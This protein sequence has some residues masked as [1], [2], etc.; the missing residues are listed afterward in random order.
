MLNRVAIGGT[1]NRVL[2][3][4][5]GLWFPDFDHVVPK[6]QNIL[7]VLS[8][9][10]GNPLVI[11]AANIV[12]DAGDIYY[13][14]NGASETPTNAF[15]ITE[16]GSA[17]TP[18]KSANRSAFTAIASTQ[19]AHAATYPK[20]NDS[21]TDNTGAGADV[22]TYLASY[23]KGDFNAASI[24]HGWVTNVTPG[25]SEPLLTGYAFAAAFGKT[26]D[27]TLKVFTNHT[28]NGV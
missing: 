27:D 19:K 24:T 12:T 15:G 13:A 22:V 28:M 4:S 3:S 21:D 2:M 17:G 16:L 26:A 8:S 25:A 20:T 5:A 7:A 6:R 23:T 18:S 1:K 11:P 9:G 10:R 14:Q